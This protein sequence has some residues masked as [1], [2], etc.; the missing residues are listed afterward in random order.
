MGRSVCSMEDHHGVRS[1]ANTPVV[2]NW[3]PKVP[4]KVLNGAVKVISR[5]RLCAARASA[6]RRTADAFEIVVEAT[7]TSVMSYIHVPVGDTVFSGTVD[8]GPAAATDSSTP[9]VNQPGPTTSFVVFQLT[10]VSKLGVAA[11]ASRD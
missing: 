5:I 2:A 3:M 11:A 4:L 10:S 6:Y 7:A 1:K 9:G 8:A